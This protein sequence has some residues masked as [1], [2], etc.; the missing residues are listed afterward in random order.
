M[1]SCIA[2]LRRF[3]ARNSNL[4][5]IHFASELKGLAVCLFFSFTMST[6]AS[7]Q[8]GFVSETVTLTIHI[9]K[10]GREL[11]GNALEDSPATL[12]AEKT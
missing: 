5:R 1:C 7:T 3:L 10:R 12:D 2:F 8:T 9:N 4:C 6:S 11:G